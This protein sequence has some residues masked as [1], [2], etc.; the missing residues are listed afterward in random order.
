MSKVLLQWQVWLIANIKLHFNLNFKTV[1]WGLL[2]DQ[3]TWMADI[4]VIRW[5]I[6]SDVWN[7]SYH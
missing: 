2:G 7:I 4:F 6:Y 5:I 3:T 1:F